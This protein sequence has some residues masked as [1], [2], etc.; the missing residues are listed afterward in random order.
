MQG[1]REGRE[2]QEDVKKKQNRWIAR[3]EER[4]ET[5][6][7]KTSGMKGMKTRRDTTEYM[8]NEK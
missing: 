8:E 1:M 2:T 3:N 7:I 6:S 4:G 5:K